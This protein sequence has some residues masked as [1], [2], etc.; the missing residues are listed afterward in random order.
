MKIE[1]HCKRK[2]RS[3]FRLILLLI[4]IILLQPA[5][6]P[7][8]FAMDLMEAYT[9]AKERDPLFGSSIYEH[10][11]ARTL[12]KQGRSFLLPQIQIGGAISRY[13]FDTAP[14]YYNDYTGRSLGISL[15]QPIFNIPKFYEYRQHN[16]RETIGDVR[17]AS[18]EQDLILRVAEAYFNGMATRHSLE[19]IDTEKKAV[20]EQLEQAKKMFRAGIATITDV[21]DAEARYDLI[22]S[23]EVEGK[24][25]LEIKIQAIK[26]IVGIEP[27]GLSFLK[28]DTPLRVP[29]PESLEGWIEIAKKHNPIL[30][31]YTYNVDYYKEEIIKNRGQHLPSVDLVAG[32][33][34]TNKSGEYLQTQNLSYTSVGIQVNIPVFSGGYISAKVKESQA[35]FEQAKKEY[36][37]ALSDNVQ[38]LTEA[39]L[40]IKGSIVRINMLLTAIRSAST[41]LH[42]NKKGLIAGVR[43]IVDVLNAERELHDVRGNLLQ[44]RYDYIMNILKLK[45]YAGTLSEEDVLMINQWLQTR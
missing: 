44:A 7:S 11:A 19:L 20:M 12:S 3:H 4:S 39:F 33:S 28:E 42:S 13:D 35:R 26:R 2:Y 30:K 36:E 40:G 1:M 37:N 38:K 23:K 6:P 34:K 14:S 15:K 45:F 41:S 43:T 32:Y 5:M 10:E 21:H 9:R 24:Y 31:S 17:F 25:N 27:D 29:E 22:L 8:L 18:A 16:I